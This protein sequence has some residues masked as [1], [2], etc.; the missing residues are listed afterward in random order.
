MIDIREMRSQSSPSRD[1]ICCKGRTLFQPTMMDG[2][3][4]KA[5]HLHMPQRAKPNEARPARPAG[6]AS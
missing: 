1:R 6:S 3:L 2:L 5:K 4:S